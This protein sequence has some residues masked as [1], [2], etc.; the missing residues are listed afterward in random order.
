MSDK[1]PQHDDE[2]RFNE[3]LKRMLETPPKPKRESDKKG[4]K[5]TG[6]KK[7]LKDARPYPRSKKQMTNSLLSQMAS[8]IRVAARVAEPGIAVSLKLS[9]S[10]GKGERREHL[11]IAACPSL[12]AVS[13]DL[14]YAD[15][16]QNGMMAASL[17]FRDLLRLEIE[18]FVIGC[19]GV[20]VDDAPYGIVLR[21]RDAGEESSAH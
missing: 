3:T 10:L 16:D 1:P 8:E 15:I 4:V 13:G 19:G 2:K 18:P 6:R 21:L 11:D 5:K 7:P 17:P 12:A 20:V 14:V 9:G